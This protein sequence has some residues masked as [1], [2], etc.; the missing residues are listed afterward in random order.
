[1]LENL[2]NRKTR[3]IA[4]LLQ[5]MGL[6]QLLLLGRLAITLVSTGLGV[7]DVSMTVMLG[8][9]AGVAGALLSFFAARSVRLGKSLG[10]VLA[11]SLALLQ[12]GS[13]LFPVSVAIF[14]CLLPDDV[15]DGIS[16]QVRETLASEKK[17]VKTE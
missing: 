4:P 12:L 1:M 13:L 14:W 8:I 17:P 9:G 6:V 2:S 10:F 3:L 15:T 7:Q 16:S 11:I 5:I